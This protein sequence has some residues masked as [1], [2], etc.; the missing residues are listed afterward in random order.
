MSLTPKRWEIAG[1]IAEVDPE[2]PGA[3]SIR[4]VGHTIGVDDEDVLVRYLDYYNHR[5]RHT[6]IGRPPPIS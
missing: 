2:V 3:R 4:D 6:A 1:F 5:R